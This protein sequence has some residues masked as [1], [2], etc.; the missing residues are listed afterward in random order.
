M[1]L[2]QLPLQ[3]QKQLN[4]LQDGEGKFADQGLDIR[5]RWGILTLPPHPCPEL[6][7]IGTD[8]FS[9]WVDPVLREM[10]LVSMGDIYRRADEWTVRGGAESQ[11]VVYCLRPESPKDTRHWW[12]G[13]LL[14]SLHYAR[15]TPKKRISPDSWSY[16]GKQWV[17][18]KENCWFCK[19]HHNWLNIFISQL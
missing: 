16:S 10:E 6:K 18:G 8:L 14:H 17:R 11:R 12:A 2:T 13:C 9:W 3:D 1:S 4:I 5:V 15:I 7:T 19:D